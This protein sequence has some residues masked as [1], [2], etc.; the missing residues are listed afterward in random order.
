MSGYGGRS[1][2]SL[3]GSGS[4]LKSMAAS[5]YTFHHVSAGDLAKSCEN[6]F[7]LAIQ[8]PSLLPPGLSLAVMKVKTQSRILGYYECVV[9]F[10][11]SR[12]FPVAR[13]IFI[14]MQIREVTTVTQCCLSSLPSSNYVYDTSLK[15]IY[16]VLVVRLLVNSCD[17]LSFDRCE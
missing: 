8:P 13:D 17:V 16:L 1:T 6:L 5:V 9:N 7:I 14:Q 10:F 11:R 2:G 12:Y 4:G 15:I 3:Y